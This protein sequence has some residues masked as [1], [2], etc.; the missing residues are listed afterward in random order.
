MGTPLSPD[1]VAGDAVVRNPLLEPLPFA[2]VGIAATSTTPLDT[3]PPT[4][5]VVAIAVVVAVDGKTDANMSN[6]APTP[7]RSVEEEAMACYKEWTKVP[8]VLTLEEKGKGK[9]RGGSEVEAHQRGRSPIY[10]ICAL[11]AL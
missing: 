6:L 1:K 8:R 4:P 11:C 3:V 9:G 5:L 7:K 10:H 2:L